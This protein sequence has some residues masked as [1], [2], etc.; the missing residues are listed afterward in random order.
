M[1]VPVAALTVPS[2]GP[3]IRNATIGAWVSLAVLAGVM[4]PINLALQNLALRRLDASAVATFS[5]VAPAL[6]VVWG[7]WFFDETLSPALLLGGAL[8]LLGVFWTS[9]PARRKGKVEVTAG[10]EG[11]PAV[12]PAD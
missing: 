1:Q 9:R 5:N 11:A 8:T 3:Q 2:W 10:P 7:V 4:T 12:V 6:T